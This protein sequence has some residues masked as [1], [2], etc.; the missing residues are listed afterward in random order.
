[1]GVVLFPFLSV[2]GGVLFGS[3][4]PFGLEVFFHFKGKERRVWKVGPLCLFWAIWKARNN[5]VFRN[6]GLSLQKIKSF[7]Y[8]YYYYYFL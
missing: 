1:M 6:E 4:Y 2:L 7:L 3:G 5:I 8:I